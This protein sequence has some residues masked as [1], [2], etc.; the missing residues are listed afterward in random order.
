MTDV[1]AH[2]ADRIATAGRVYFVAGVN[3]MWQMEWPLGLFTSILG[4][5]C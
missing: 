1:I 5:R 4:L 2:V 3:A